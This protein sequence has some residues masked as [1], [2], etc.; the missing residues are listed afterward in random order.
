MIFYHKYKQLLIS[1]VLPA[2]LLCNTFDAFSG[3]APKYS[4]TPFPDQYWCQSAPYPTSY[5]SVGTF[6]INETDVKGF[7]KGQDKN[8]IIT[9]PAGFQFNTAVGTVSFAASADITGI[10][11]NLFNATTLDIQVVTDD[12]DFFD[13]IYYNNYE[14]RAMA[15]GNSGDLVRTGGTFKIDNQEACAN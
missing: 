5:V 11:I 8:I 3:G 15:A 7:K 2:C 6:A 10:T 1:V 4:V 14:I 9:L 12:D 13:T